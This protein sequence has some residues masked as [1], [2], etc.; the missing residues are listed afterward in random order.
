MQQNDRVSPINNVAP[1]AGD[2]DSTILIVDDSRTQLELLRYCLEQN[3]YRVTTAANGA[4]AVREARRE[5]PALIIS[6]IVMPVMDGYTMCSA[7]KSD[8]GLQDIPVMLLTSLASAEDVIHGLNARADYYI[9]KPFD[10]KYL[11]SRVRHI[12]QPHPLPVERL[13]DSVNNAEA[14]SSEAHSAQDGDSLQVFLD[15]KSYVVHA[16]RRQMLN[17]LLSTYENAVQRN[18]E[19]VRTQMELRLLNEQLGAQQKSL[20]EANAR[21]ETLA[22]VD[23]L[24]GLKNH[25]TFQEELEREYQ[26]CRRY[27]PELSLLLLDVD[28]F[29]QYND[30]YGHPAGDEVLKQV[31][32]YIACEARSTDLAARYGGEE[33]AVVL[34]STGAAGAAIFGERLRTAIMNAP[35]PQRT[36]TASI[37]IATFDT[38]MTSRSTLV[39][40]ADSALYHSKRSGRN[41]VTMAPALP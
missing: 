37:G 3:G 25:R 13:A 30:T 28:H 22:T 36:I 39:A 14:H 18:N 15:G 10:E 38:S 6:D 8:S 1:V 29:K 34:S 31:A 4:E 41:R 27:G 7:I 35:W 12:L 16:E 33:F 23:G 2:C 5:K 9:T 24:T 20:Q 19:L 11:S 32:Q 21:L 26:K 17:L 40:Q